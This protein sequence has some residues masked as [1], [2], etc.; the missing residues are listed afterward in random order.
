[1]GLLIVGLCRVDHLVVS[2]RLFPRGSCGRDGIACAAGGCSEGARWRCD[3]RRSPR[4]LY[5]P[6]ELGSGVSSTSGSRNHILE[7]GEEERR[8]GRVEA[9]GLIHRTVTFYSSRSSSFRFDC[10]WCSPASAQ[11]N[12]FAF[13]SCYL[14]PPAVY[15]R[16]PV[17]ISVM[18]RVQLYSP[19]SN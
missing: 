1:M 14:L 18:G 19:K 11:R 13:Q 6:E 4:R 10:C 16:D 7:R 2:R 17:P 12:W 15:Y 9:T 5:S 8:R 3:L